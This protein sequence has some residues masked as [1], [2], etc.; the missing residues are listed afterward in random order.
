MASAGS[1]KGGT[2]P[3]KAFVNNAFSLAVSFGVVGLG[4][5]CFKANQK[6]HG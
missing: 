4:Q 2:D 5:F 3:R 1:W 6:D